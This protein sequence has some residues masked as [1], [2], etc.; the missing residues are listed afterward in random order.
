MLEFK[1]LGFIV[2]YAAIVPLTILG[3]RRYPRPLSI[4]PQDYCSAG[5]LAVRP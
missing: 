3:L 1:Q 5:H 2:K 4:P